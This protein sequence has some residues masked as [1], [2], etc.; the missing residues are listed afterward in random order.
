MTDFKDLE[1]RDVVAAGTMARAIAESAQDAFLLLRDAEFSDN[2]DGEYFPRCSW[3]QNRDADGIP[4][5]SRH[6]A[7]CRWLA[8]MR[9]VGLIARD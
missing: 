3:C 5:E 4:W 1:S 9:K 7:D 6:S 2:S 8:L